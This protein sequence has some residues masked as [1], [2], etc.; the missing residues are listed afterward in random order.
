[1]LIKK[2]AYSIISISIIMTLILG[3]ISSND[4]DFSALSQQLPTD[5]T[6]LQDLISKSLD[7][8]HQADI[9]T[10]STNILLNGINLTQGEF[11]LLY[12]STPFGSKGHIAVNLPC[13]PD[14][15]LDPIFDIL[16]G[17]APD[18]YVLPLGYLEQISKPGKMCVY[19]GQFG[20]GDPVTDLILKYVGDDPIK[21]EGPHSIVISAHEFYNPTTESYFERSHNATN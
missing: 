11:I 8:V 1:M 17:R 21:L 5:Q 19:H 14:N 9:S 3:V 2:N 7:Y 12:D 13:N 6:Q 20:F 15:P 4:E 10:T 18:L 16:V